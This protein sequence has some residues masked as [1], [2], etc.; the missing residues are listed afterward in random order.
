VSPRRARTLR[1]TDIR[2][3]WY[4]TNTTVPRAVLLSLDGTAPHKF[5]GFPRHWLPF[6]AWFE[7]PWSASVAP[8]TYIP[9]YSDASEE[10]LVDIIGRSAREGTLRTLVES[11]TLH[12]AI[13]ADCLYIVDH[14]HRLE[15][16]QV[17]HE[18]EE[19]YRGMVGGR[20]PLALNGW[21]SYGRPCL[22]ALEEAALAA[23]RK[24]PRAIVL[25]C[26]LRRPY[27]YSYTHK[28]ISRV[29]AS[30]KISMEAADKI[31]MTSLGVLPEV[32]WDEPQ[33]VGYMAGV[34]DIYRVLRLARS[35]FASHRYDVVF[36]CL[37][38]EP[39]SDVLRIIQREGLIGGITKIRG[40]GRKPFYIR[41]TPAGRVKAAVVVRV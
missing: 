16:R 25:P 8:P 32:V 9:F 18:L 26:A 3:D 2:G 12:D 14:R 39:Y 7:L 11:T 17:R 5:V 6:F 41:S 27:Q 36:D 28:K 15:P 33:V 22:R 35:F 34:P 30:R 4:V 31:V 19:L 38:F 20:K 23:P 24:F 40:L 29:L 37:Q 10:E 21:Q 1:F 13:L